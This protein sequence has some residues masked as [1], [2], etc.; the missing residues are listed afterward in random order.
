MRPTKKG[1]T[2]HRAFGLLPPAKPALRH[3]LAKLFVKTIVFSRAVCYTISRKTKKRQR[4][5][6]AYPPRPAQ[7][8]HPPAQ[9]H[10]AAPPFHYTGN[11]PSF[12][13][14]SQISWNGARHRRYAANALLIRFCRMTKAVLGALS[15]GTALHSFFVF[16]KR[17]RGRG[18]QIIAMQQAAVCCFFVFLPRVSVPPPMENR[19]W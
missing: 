11:L 15:V 5:R 6:S 13:A 18:F 19:I 17:P 12:Q 16:R 14:G 3:P 1:Q 10:Y 9:Q 2:P 7:V 4:G 8:Q